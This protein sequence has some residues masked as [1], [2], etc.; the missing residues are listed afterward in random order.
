[1]SHT[2]QA[3]TLAAALL[4]LALFSRP[5][6]AQVAKTGRVYV[7]NRSAE[8]VT[9]TCRYYID[10]LGNRQTV[11]GGAWTVLPNQ[12][13]FLN[14]QGNPFFTSRFELTVTTRAGSTDWHMKTADGPNALSLRIDAGFLARHQARLAPPP[15]A[16]RPVVGGPTDE[17]IKRALL[18]VLLA[19]GTHAMAGKEPKDV[20]E[21]IVI[22][23]AVRARDG[24]VESALTDL[25]PG[26]PAR[27]VQAARVAICLALDGK[28]TERNF[29][30]AQAREAAMARLRA[31]NP[32]MANTAALADFIAAVAEARRGR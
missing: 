19:A 1:M 31:A 25:F 2:R 30:R 16:P 6:P 17:A 15:F 22:A 28:L 10:A 24:L 8:T 11:R 29:N 32:G 27:D 26:Q 18:K 9:I 5:A 3:L 20:G 23:L 7:D 21:A 12:A 14:D 13:G 4:G